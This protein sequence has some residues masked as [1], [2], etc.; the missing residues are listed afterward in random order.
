MAVLV[1]KDLACGAFWM[2]ALDQCKHGSLYHCHI[3]NDNNIFLMLATYSAV[4]VKSIFWLRKFMSWMFNQ[5]ILAAHLS[6]RTFSCLF[7]LCNSSSSDWL[8]HFLGVLTLW[9]W[10]CL[11]CSSSTAG[12]LTIWNLVFPCKDQRKSKVKLQ[13]TLENELP[14]AMFRLKLYIARSLVHLPFICAM[15]DWVRE[16]GSEEGEIT[17]RDDWFFVLKRTW[18]PPYVLRYQNIYCGLF[19]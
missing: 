18:V 6:A 1:D 7:I 10:L 17:R 19:Q 14:S 13:D 8:D 9:N 12:S 5:L 4:F 11:N 3:S 15:M 2:G 16:G